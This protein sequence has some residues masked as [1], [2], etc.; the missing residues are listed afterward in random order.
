MATG[1]TSVGDLVN[2][3]LT[4]GLSTVTQPQLAAITNEGL[5]PGGRAVINGRMPTPISFPGIRQASLRQLNSLDPQ[6]Q[7]NLNTYLVNNHNLQFQ[8]W[9]DQAQRQFGGGG[10]A[11]VSR[12][13]GSAF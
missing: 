6:E 7:A 12:F 4:G 3:L 1:F 9:M 2:S 11:P 5:A 10:F 8:P 13:A